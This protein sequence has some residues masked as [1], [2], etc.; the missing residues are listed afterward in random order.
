MRKT[1]AAALAACTLGFASGGA[2]AVECFD[3]RTIAQWDALEN[4]SCTQGDKSWTL[5]STTLADPI[6]VLFL[7]PTE[8]SHGVF[9]SG[10]DTSNLPGNWVINYT[11]SVTD[12]NFYISAMFA[13]SDSSG[14][15]SSLVTKDVTGDESFTLLVVDGVPDSELGLVATTLTVNEAIH[16]DGNEDLVSVSNTFR[17][18]Q[19]AVPEPGTLFLLGFGLVAAAAVRRRRR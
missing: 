2:L 4:N 3:V 1:L 18:D 6:T 12:P 19:R 7:N 10:F 9:I 15:A 5:N 8:N 14:P 13:D 11:I 17:Q 16:V